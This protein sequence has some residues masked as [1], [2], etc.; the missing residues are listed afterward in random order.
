MA[1]KPSVHDLIFV[2][3]PNNGKQAQLT[4][5]TFENLGV[6][7]REHLENWIVNHP[8]LLGTNLLVITT[9]TTSSTALI[10]G[11]ISSP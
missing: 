1:N 11:W 5:E 4:P 3:E 10:R 6:K 8:K 2:L 7:E 9:D